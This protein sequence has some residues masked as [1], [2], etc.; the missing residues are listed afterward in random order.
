MLVCVRQL[1]PLVTIPLLPE[2]NSEANG[3]HLANIK[4][5]IIKA[6][7]IFVLVIKI[8]SQE[9]CLLIRRRNDRVVAV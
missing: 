6:T 5:K 9:V 7:I 4:S 1:L 3:L 2:L 8:E